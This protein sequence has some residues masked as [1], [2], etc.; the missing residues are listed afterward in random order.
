VF[1]KRIPG[2]FPDDLNDSFLGM[3]DR[4]GFPGECPDELMVSGGIPDE[5]FILWTL[6]IYFGSFLYA[7]YC[8]GVLG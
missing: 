3:V 5:H 7:L 2:E 1:G 8:G 4:D 6:L